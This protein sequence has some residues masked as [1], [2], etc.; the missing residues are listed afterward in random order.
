MAWLIKT[1]VTPL[2]HKLCPLRP[3]K[4]QL[5]V[6]STPSLWDLG[7]LF[8]GRLRNKVWR[9]PFPPLKPPKL[10]CFEWGRIPA[11]LWNSLA[12]PRYTRAP[13]GGQMDKRPTIDN[14]SPFSYNIWGGNGWLLMPKPFS[15]RWLN[16]IVYGQEFIRLSHNIMTTLAI[17]YPITGGVNTYGTT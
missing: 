3:Q 2:P 4:C 7:R 12:N 8:V 10:N 15:K 13:S 1:Y 11:R 14:V 17:K 5:A 9:F 6:D 16:N